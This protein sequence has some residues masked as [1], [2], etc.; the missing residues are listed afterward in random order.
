M[1][2]DIKLRVFNRI[3]DVNTAA[4]DRLAEHT[5]YASARWMAFGE[6]VIAHEKPF[7]VVVSSGDSYFCS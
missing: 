7:Y 3:R 6:Q 2:N 1:V 5:N 4:W